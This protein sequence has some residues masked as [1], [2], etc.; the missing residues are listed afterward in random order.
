MN[1]QDL[2]SIIVN[3]YNSENYLKQCLN[4]LVNQTYSNIEVIVIDNQSIDNTKKIIKSF[5]DE[6][7]K[8]FFTKKFLSLGAAR[9]FGISHVKGKYLA[10]LDSDDTWER[11]KIFKSISFFNDKFGLIYSNVNYFS[12]DESFLLYSIRKPYSGICF[13]ELAIDYSLCLSSCL[14]SKELIENY[15]IKFNSKLEVCEDYD[16]FLKL[17][18][19]TQVFYLD[20]PLVNYRIHPLNLTNTKRELFFKETRQVIDSFDNLSIEIKKNILIKNDLEESKYEWKKKNIVVALFKLWSIKNFSI[21][22]A[23]FYS[24]I[25]LFPHTLIYKKYNLIRGSKKN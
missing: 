6:R 12:L 24:I 14:F 13:K 17:T 11:E 2:V 10:F 23:V 21:L 4:S 20:E 8:Y 18:Y 3:C 25:F 19:R 22:K 15:N 9:N 16:F 5:K 1:N 7:I